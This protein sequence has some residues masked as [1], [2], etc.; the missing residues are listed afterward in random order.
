MSDADLDALFA[1]LDERA[2]QLASN[3]Q[4]EIERDSDEE[5]RRTNHESP[6]R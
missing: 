5:L 2:I 3:Y 4:D 6:S 1:L